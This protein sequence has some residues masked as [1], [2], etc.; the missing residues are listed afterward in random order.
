[1]VLIKKDWKVGVRLKLDFF[2]D[3]WTFDYYFLG[4]NKEIGYKHDTYSFIFLF[5][6]FVVK[7][8]KQT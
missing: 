4:Y 5:I 3:F 1:M 6:G 7:I 2:R 8:G